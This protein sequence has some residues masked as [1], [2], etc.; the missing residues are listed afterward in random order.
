MRFIFLYA[1]LFVSTVS[2][3]QLKLSLPDAIALAVKG[4]PHYQAERYNLDIARTAVTTAGLHLNP[5]LSLSAI[6]IPSAK[7]YAP[8]TGFFTPDNRQMN[9]QV[10]KVFQ[11]G[12]QLKYKIQAAESDLKIVSSNLSEYEWNLRSE[13]ASK[14]LDA[15]YAD[16]KLKLIGQARINSDTLLKVNKIRLKNQVI[17][18]TEFS[19]TQINDEQYRLM[20]LSALQALKSEKNNLALLLGT[21]D[22]ILIDKN[23]EWFP[24][25]LPQSYD[26]LLKFALVNRKE[27]LV[28][29]NLLDKAKIDIALQKAISKPQPELGLNYS[30]QNSIP[31]LGV[32]LAIPL[33]F[34]DRNQGEIARARIAAD[35]ADLMINAYV[36]Q[37][38]KEVRNA[39]DEF[40]TNKNSWER[41]TELNKAS[42][43]VLQTVKLSYLK[44]GTT[45]L[46][47]LEAERTWFDMQNQYYEAMYN[48]RKSYLQLFFTCDFSG[49]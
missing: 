11:V 7:Y 6:A 4:N 36:L 46:D 12:G 25:M 14:W 2:Q 41:Y 43:S 16:E 49:S 32:S 38:T 37:V 28:S 10:S 18:T 30:P 23:T 47:Y 31:Y 21:K 17:T 48:Y 40:I 19:R 27:I 26:S 34:S 44:G 3:A 45:I 42:E 29:K 1:L 9:Y 39:Y 24:A 8:G 15:W 13:V 33:P 20:Y 22:S 5:T 35:Q